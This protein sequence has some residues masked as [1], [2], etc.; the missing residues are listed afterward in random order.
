MKTFI[1]MYVTVSMIYYLLTVI[2]F[3]SSKI[4]NSIIGIYT[5]HS[6]DGDDYTINQLKDD[7]LNDVGGSLV[8]YQLT[9]HISGLIGG[10][11]LPFRILKSI[12]NK[13]RGAK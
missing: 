4:E 3:N 2:L 9:V 5:L 6:S 11:G 13:I 1:L 8:K 7:M 10:F 12:S